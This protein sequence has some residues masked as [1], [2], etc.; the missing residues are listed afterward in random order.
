MYNFKDLE[1][2][3]FCHFFTILNGCFQK[4]SHKNL[5]PLH[6]P[7]THWFT[8]YKKQKILFTIFGL[9][10]GKNCFFPKIFHLNRPPDTSIWMSEK[11]NYWQKKFLFG[12]FELKNPNKN[13]KTREQNDR[14]LDSL[15][16][17]PFTP[18]L[19]IGE[20]KR[21]SMEDEEHQFAHQIG[22]RGVSFA[23]SLQFC[24]GFPQFSNNEHRFHGTVV[25]HCCTII[26]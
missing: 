4:N 11:A 6:F 20:G 18:Y 26:P 24:I 14:Y 23:Y 22:I 21:S 17:T 25:T 7:L 10:M 13:E 5:A 12:F 15:S 8:S 2:G 19:Y 3:K 9:K 1:M 16:P